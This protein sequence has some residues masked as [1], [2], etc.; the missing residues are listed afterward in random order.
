MNTFSI[1]NLFSNI[2][3]IWRPAY[4][5]YKD[6]DTFLYSVKEKTIKTT[7]TFTDNYRSC[8]VFE[9]FEE[10]YSL[11][12]I[13]NYSCWAINNSIN[14]NENAYKLFIMPIEIKGRRNKLKRHMLAQEPLIDPYNPRWQKAAILTLI[15]KPL[16]T[17]GETILACN[18]KN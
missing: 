15:K 8:K 1:N 16:A 5:I 10:A 6:N 4:I 17:L 13:Y 11:V 3:L 18:E 2:G 9:N 7:Y 12:C 14:A